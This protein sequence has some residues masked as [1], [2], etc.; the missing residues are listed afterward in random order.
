MSAGR[1]IRQFFFGRDNDTWLTLL[2]IGLGLVVVAYGWSMRRDWFYL[3]GNEGDLLL[4]RRLSE[5]MVASHSRFVPTLAWL[6]WLAAKLGL[7]EPL[8]LSFAWC[9]LLLAGCFLVVGIFSRAAAV[10]AWFVHL[11]AAQSGMLVTYGAD[12]LITI[13]LFYLMLAPLPDRFALDRPV[14]KQKSSDAEW[15]GFFRRILQLH[16]CLIY[17]FSGL[18]KALGS[19]WWTGA[20]LWHAL[21]RSPFDVVPP[22]LL[23]KVSWALPPLGVLAVALELG[24]PICIWLK[25]T[26]FIWLVLICGMHAA[27]GIFMAM[28]LFALVMIALNLAA[29]A[30]RLHP[31]NERF[32]LDAATSSPD[33]EPRPIH[34]RHDG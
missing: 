13:G 33:A 25:E 5:A 6:T 14:F 26:R 15:L 3:F 9:W 17:S 29:F 2:R 10:T 18:A 11:C 32:R 30:P 8:A 16:L 31:P 28:P 22:A 19:G 34:L 12:N 1:R 23:A 24:Y 7:S 27:I 4:F 20:S 21:T